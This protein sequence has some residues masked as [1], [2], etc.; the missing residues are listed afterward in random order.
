MQ[1]YNRITAPCISI[2][3]AYLAFD[4]AVIFQ[5]LQLTLPSG[6]WTSLLGPSGVGKSTLLRL[7]ANL[8]S[9]DTDS[10]AVITVDNA[11]PLAHQIAYM[12]Q[13]DLLLPWLNV[14][15][16]VL[17][18]MRLRGE[19]ASDQIISRERAREL[20]AQTGL[21]TA[22]KK[23]P[24]NLS[25]GMRQRA[26]LVRTLIENKMVV[27]MDEP[28]SALDAITRFNLQD[29]A[30]ELLRDRT[31]FFI[32]HDPLEALRV[33][34]EIIVMSGQ[35]AMLSAPLKL[36]SAWPRDLMSPELTALQAD[37]YATLTKAHEETV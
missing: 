13:A 2:Q 1:K 22:E 25:G 27:L 9:P 36:H 8:S 12:A 6:K 5:N 19:S 30:V 10:H 24:R 34:D 32:T 7:I 26:A 17:L 37:L 3:D 18:S 29:L 16:N 23:F 14:L 35:P 31:V 28:F 21:Q 11:V 4:H 20:L 33:S 15:E